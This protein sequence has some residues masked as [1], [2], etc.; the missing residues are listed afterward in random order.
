[1]QV[2]SPDLYRVIQ[3]SGQTIEDREQMGSKEKFWY[4]EDQ[5]SWLF[6][7]CRPGTGEDW[8]EKLAASIA[9]KLNLPHA[10]VELAE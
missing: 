8:A 5:T 1:M 9:A 4:R 3:V 6:K 7:V 10:V 2:C